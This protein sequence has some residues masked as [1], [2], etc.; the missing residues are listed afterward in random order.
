[1]DE[2]YHRVAEIERRTA[3]VRERVQ[4]RRRA[5][6]DEPLG[7]DLGTVSVSGHGELLAIKLNRDSLRFTN[8]R[9]LGDEIVRAVHRAERKA[10]RG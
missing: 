5:R 9:A 2:I 10:G 4:A 1:M 8:A 3:E 6:I 7:S